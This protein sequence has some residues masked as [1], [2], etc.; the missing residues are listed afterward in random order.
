MQIKIL[1][2]FSQIIFYCK[3]SWCLIKFS[4]LATEKR[5][6]FFDP[7]GNIYEVGC[8]FIKKLN[9][10][11]L[12]KYKIKSINRQSK[13]DIPFSDLISMI[14]SSRSKCISQ[15]GERVHVKQNY[16]NSTVQKNKD[17]I[18]YGN[19]KINYSILDQHDKEL[20]TY[21]LDM[22]GYSHPTINCTEEYIEILLILAFSGVYATPE[23]FNTLFDI[24]VE[25]REDPNYLPYSCNECSHKFKT[26]EGLTQHLDD[27]GHYD[28]FFEQYPYYEPLIK[29][30]KKYNHTL[31]NKAGE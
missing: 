25:K 22:K 7:Y 29:I 16:F 24:T 9:K 15:A 12:E 3:I 1:K 28:S 14:T 10:C 21:K 18:Y 30:R 27:T 17:G 4:L 20:F 26:H 23:D 6:I 5:I 13:D 31:R 19:A 8:F 11:D 2:F